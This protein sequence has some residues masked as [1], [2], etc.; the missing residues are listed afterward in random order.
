MGDDIDK[1]KWKFTKSGKFIVKSLY[2]KISSAGVD[3]SFKH[4]WKAKLPLKIKI[5]LWPP[6]VVSLKKKF[7]YMFE[8]YQHP[9]A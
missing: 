9:Q 8:T 5:W 4:L 3:R 2:N 6:T 1:P 7:I